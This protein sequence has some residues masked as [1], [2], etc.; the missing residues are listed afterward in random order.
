VEFLLLKVLMHLTL[1][2]VVLRWIMQEVAVAVVVVVE[3]VQELEVVAVTYS[4]HPK[5][6]PN[7]ISYVS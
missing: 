2:L 7:D 5:D 1:L 6:L 3:V 4:N